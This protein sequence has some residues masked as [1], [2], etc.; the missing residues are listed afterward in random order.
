MTE[1]VLYIVIVLLT[2]LVIATLG[3]VYT[4]FTMN[5]QHSSKSEIDVY[6]ATRKELQEIKTQI[7]AGQDWD[8]FYKLEPKKNAEGKYNPNEVSG[9][10]DDMF[11]EN[12]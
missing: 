11:K 6:D 7:K 5:M 10:L 4:I 2:L 3:I 8:A 9:A 12:K 1:V